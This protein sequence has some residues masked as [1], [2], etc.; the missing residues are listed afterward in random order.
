MGRAGFVEERFDLLLLNL[1]CK[2]VMRWFTTLELG[3]ANGYRP[4]LLMMVAYLL[5][6]SLEVDFD[7][8]RLVFSCFM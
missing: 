1:S 2:Q 8:I 6:H 4:L 5:Y 7:F 3:S